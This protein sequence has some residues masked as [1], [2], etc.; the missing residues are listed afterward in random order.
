[1]DI[2]SNLRVCINIDVA[3]AVSAAATAA[4]KSKSQPVFDD[5]AH[6]LCGFPKVY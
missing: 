3:D 1:L 2:L 5:V 4:V 6:I